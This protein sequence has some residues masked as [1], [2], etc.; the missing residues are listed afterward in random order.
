MICYSA[1]DED[2]NY[3]EISELLND[4]PDFEVGDII[5]KAE[6]WKPSLTNMIDVDDILDLV[7]DRA[8]DIG[9]EYAED[10]IYQVG[11]DKEL[12]VKIE[13][14][15]KRLG[16]KFPEVTF[17]NVGKSEEYILTEKDFEGI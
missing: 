3:Q 2:F 13:Q 10:W 16:K 4:Y 5:Y 8:Y 15:L 1:N 12:R 11:G 9:G 14:S 17:Y 6:A 7:Y